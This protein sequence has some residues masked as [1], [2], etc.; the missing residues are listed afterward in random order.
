LRILTAGEAYVKS[1]DGRHLLHNEAGNEG[2][3]PLFAVEITCPER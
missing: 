1:K 3:I 2:K